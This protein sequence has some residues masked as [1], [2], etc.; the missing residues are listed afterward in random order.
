MKPL[1]LL[2]I[3]SLAANAALIALA[4]RSKS[5]PFSTAV[6]SPHTTAATSVGASPT[7]LTQ[8]TSSAS[9][10]D[11]KTWAT[12][13]TGD[14]K[15]MAER[16]RTAGFPL[17]IVRAILTAQIDER[18][19]AQRKAL[20]ANQPETPFW[21]RNSYSYDPKLMS[22]MRELNRQE[23]KELREQLGPDGYTGSEERRN[24][25]RRQFGD[26]PADKIDQMQSIISDYGDLRSEVYANANGVMLPED[27]EKVAL[28]DKEQRADLTSVLTPE[29]LENYELR[30]SSTASTIRSQLSIFKPTEQE[31]RALFKA[32]R[33]AEA[34][35]GT[36]A[37][38]VTSPNQAE[39]LRNA[40]LADL[41]TSLSPERYAELK[42]AIDPKY[43]MTNRLVARLELPPSAAVKVVKIQEE[44][45]QALATLRSDSKFTPEQRS[46]LLGQISEN[47]MNK[48]TE[49]LT[50]RGLEAYKN[51]G[52]SWLHALAPQPQKPKP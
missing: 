28:L 14:P 8:G 42:Q 50:P 31:F 51:Y 48:L 18:Y 33:A 2:L 52:G 10:I 1:P 15:T 13:Q 45:Q 23:M 37:G 26:L 49:T 9:G 22:T 6:S 40:V 21:Q 20:L 25:Q 12:L 11:A 47:V 17:A 27:R 19:A 5:G 16:L 3:L 43:Q 39:D 41:Q 7:D 35:Y 32:T 24:W 46:A 4:V 44:A 30:S 36:L 38:G 34:Q 29:E